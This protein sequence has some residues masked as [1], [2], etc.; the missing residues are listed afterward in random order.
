MEMSTVISSFSKIIFALLM[1]VCGADSHLERRLG[2]QKRVVAAR[3][4][5]V[6]TGC[7][8]V[9]M[10]LLICRDVHPFLL[11]PP[12]LL[13]ALEM[14]RTRDSLHGRVA[15][16]MSPE[17]VPHPS[18]AHGYPVSSGRLLPSVSVSSPVKWEQFLP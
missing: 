4:R 17:T 18:G 5:K 15:K 8:V 11:T 9:E 14:S 16:T 13:P 6:G 1:H 7:A 3:P 12:A 10:T 2:G